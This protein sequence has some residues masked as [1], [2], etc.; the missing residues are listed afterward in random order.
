MGIGQ[1][2]VTTIIIES[3]EGGA[4]S[5]Q[6]LHSESS[7]GAREWCYSDSTQTPCG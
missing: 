3:S 6:R 2:V 4:S 1:C 5:E 7:S